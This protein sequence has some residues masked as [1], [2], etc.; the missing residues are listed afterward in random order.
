MC[1][2]TE[3]ARCPSG[4]SGTCFA[5]MIEPHFFYCLLLAV[6]LI[7]ITQAP[8]VGHHRS[9]RL[10]V[11]PNQKVCGLFMAVAP[12]GCSDTPSIGANRSMRLRMGPI[13][14]EGWLAGKLCRASEEAA[15]AHV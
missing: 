6:S 10:R 1:W 3:R 15:I 12:I 8:F 5:L 11:W 9:I 13:Q 4:L 7:G 14:G 2:Q